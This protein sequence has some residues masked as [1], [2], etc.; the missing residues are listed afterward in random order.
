MPQVIDLVEIASKNKSV[1]LERLAEGRRLTQELRQARSG[2]LR[3]KRARPLTR[4][5]IKIID[6]LDSD[7]RLTRLASLNKAQHK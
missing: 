1:D 5:R 3:D 4:R 2:V 6:D 7:P